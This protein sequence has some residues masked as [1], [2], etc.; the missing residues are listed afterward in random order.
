M[1]IFALLRYCW[2]IGIRWNWRVAFYLLADDARGERKYGLDTTG[3]DELQHLKKENKSIAHAT[4]YMP[5]SYSLLQELLAK[6]PRHCRQHFVDIGSGKGRAVAVAAHVGFAK[7]TGI[8]FS[9]KLCKAAQ[10]NIKLTQKLV[11]DCTLT[12]T[13]CNA[14][15]YPIPVDADCIF[16]FNPFDEFVM[17]T[18]LSNL[19]ISIQKHH[20]YLYVI[21][22]NPQFKNLFLQQGFREIYSTK[23]LKYIEATIFELKQYKP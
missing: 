19:L 3:A 16:L 18:V 13:C 7:S 14:E 12:I 11:P 23:K 1:R 21:Y 10:A 8:D 9:E 15:N 2:F 5:V 4:I 17:K 20:R 22:V 6:L